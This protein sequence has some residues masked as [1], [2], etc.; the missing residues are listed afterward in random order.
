M[1]FRSVA[2]SK[3]YKGNYH[4]AEESRN[5]DNRRNPGNVLDLVEWFQGFVDLIAK[6]IPRRRRHVLGERCRLHPRDPDCLAHA[7]ASLLAGEIDSAGGAH[8]FTLAGCLLSLAA[9]T[10][11]LNSI[12][13][14]K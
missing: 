6:A 5:A 11:E 3:G 10:S 14:S 9:N 2:G 4:E 13:S 12:K 8:V 1:L 7:D